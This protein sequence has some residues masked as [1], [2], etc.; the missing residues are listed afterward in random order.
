[1]KSKQEYIRLI[2]PFLF[3]L[4]FLSIAWTLDKGTI[5]K[6]NDILETEINIKDISQKIHQSEIYA[7]K[8][9]DVL[10][11]KFEHVEDLR[12]SILDKY[13]KQRD[14]VFFEFHPN[15]MNEN[16]ISLLVYYNDSLK[17]WNNNSVSIESQ[18]SQTHLGDR[19]VTLSNAYYIAKIKKS[20]LYKIVSLIHIGDKFEVENKFLQNKLNLNLGF[21]NN[22]VISYLPGKYG[23][24]IYDKSG[25][26]L[27]SI[28]KNA[29]DLNEKPFFAFIIIL[30]IISVL[31]LIF[32]SQKLFVALW[33]MSSINWV[34]VTLLGLLIGIRFIMMKY[35]I[36]SLIYN[37]DFFH[38]RLYGGYFLMPNLGDGLIQ[39]ILLFLFSFQFYKH[40]DIIRITGL[41]NRMTID[42]EKQSKPK[43]LLISLFLISFIGFY[44]FYFSCFAKSLIG[45]SKIYFEI[46]KV[47]GIQI[48]TIIAL[49]VL[50][51]IFL[52]FIFV[53]ERIISVWIKIGGVR[54]FIIQIFIILVIFSPYIYAS[55]FKEELFNQIDTVSVVFFLIVIASIVLIRKYEIGFRYYVYVI[56]VFLFAVYLAITILNTMDKTE[57]EAR[58]ALVNIETEQDGLGEFFLSEINKKIK[59]DIALKEYIENPYIN[60]DNIREHLVKRYFNDYL[61]KYDFSLTICGLD[62]N[63]MV[64]DK[65]KWM[66]CYEYFEIFFDS[67]A[68]PIFESDFFR[69][70]NQIGRLSYAGWIPFQKTDSSEISLIINL[71][72]KITSDRL[73][74]PELLIDEKYN[75]Y[76]KKS[77]LSEYSFARYK[78][79]KLV[80]Q[81]GKFPYNLDLGAYPGSNRN[82]NYFDYNEYNH[83]IYNYE[84]R[85]SIIVSRPIVKLIDRIA[86]LTYIFLFYYIVLSLFI[87]IRKVPIDLNFNKLDLK[88]KIQYSM[89][90]MLSFS[91]L[92]IGGVS[93]YDYLK[94]YE[95]KHNEFILERI[96]SVAVELENQLNDQAR[97][98]PYW[99]NIKYNSLD[100]L[101]SSIALVFNTDINLYNPDGFLISSSRWE[102]FKKGLQGILMDK[103]AFKALNYEYRSKFIQDEYIGKLKYLSAYIPLRNKYNSVV[104][105]VNLPYFSK[106]D[107]LKGEISTF[108]V[109]MIN[110]YALLMLI[111]VLIAVLISNRII[112]PLRLIQSKFREFELGKKNELILYGQE[113]E[114][115]SLIKEYNRMLVELEQSAELLA[116]SEREGAWREM[117][118]QIAHE[119]KNPLTPMKLSMQ[120]LVRS[121]NNKDKGFS[122][123]LNKVSNTITEQIDRLS[124]IA[125][126]FSNFA[127]IPQAHNEIVDIVAILNNSL[128]LFEN[129]EG[130]EFSSN[131]HFFSPTEVFADKEQLE[132]VFINLIK[133][134]IQAMR[135]GIK[136]HIHIEM[137][138]NKKRVVVK[139]IDNGIGIPEN[140]H[141]KLFRPNF[142]TKSSGMGLGLSIVKNIIENADGK[143]WFETQINKGTTFFVQLPVY[144]RPIEAIPEDL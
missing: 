34:L 26:F 3:F 87:L 10:L 107:I 131:L 76:L 86:T 22:T 58:L 111:S 137:I 17:Y 57:K 39:A 106:Q 62:D 91:L 118:K 125:T 56:G 72:S 82:Y 31:L 94:Q 64:E 102:I 21:R 11:N 77:R 88:F 89:I 65:N 61:R 78:K 41:Y 116:K 30:Y 20:G 122:V 81:N 36:P 16:S 53:L 140:L 101:V 4:L 127:K 66:N 18:F 128:Q 2:V 139:V 113:D 143:I 55:R 46:Y 1:M 37:L 114:I 49:M 60:R 134:A 109:A 115:G 90:I 51:F 99:T 120:L 28:E 97:I 43:I 136:N 141:E 100:E 138:A 73:G 23:C 47:L 117:A 135:P 32:F 50:G 14:S 133:N 142:T 96:N 45:N 68:S 71:D 93:V 74:Y 112:Q 84:G 121:W 130:V 13:K 103:N 75:K 129:T 9:I 83:L 8:F 105:Y 98:S 24:N 48:Y 27:F 12:Y 5:F 92:L 124:N 52:S 110:I 54:I 15:E 19:F 80:H 126:S 108:V 25:E 35:Q 40:W 63:I 7:E 44:F 6:S 70:E 38:P 85:K 144:Q 42:K 132:R 67:V 33:S 123:R 104:C 69:Y 59:K 29:S 119:I 95:N 79:G